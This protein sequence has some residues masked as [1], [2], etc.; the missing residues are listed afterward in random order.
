MS[1]LTSSRG[2]VTGGPVPAPSP[3]I[4]VLIYWWGGEQT[5]TRDSKQEQRNVGMMLE[6]VPW[7]KSP[8]FSSP[9]SGSL[10]TSVASQSDIN[11]PEGGRGRLYQAFHVKAPHLL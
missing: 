9:V 1:L 7:L 4:P 11:R 5:L 2:C 6:V 8:Y 10:K 3:A